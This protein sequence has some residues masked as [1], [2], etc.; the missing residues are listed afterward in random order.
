MY[1]SLML[2]IVEVV[3]G[4]RPQWE[5]FVEMWS[6]EEYAPL[7]SAM[8]DLASYLVDCYEQGKTA[9]FPALFSLVETQYGTDD[10]E[11]K[12]L[13]ALG[14]LETMQSVASHRPFGFQV[15]REWLGPRTL[16]SW[17]EV[18]EGMRRVAEWTREQNRPRW[19]QFWRRWTD[20]NPK[21]AL[22]EVESPELKRILE[23]EFR[24]LGDE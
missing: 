13:V 19:W 24:D 7:Y 18:D 4:F 20:F 14:L 5:A 2:E 22:A 9:E 16:V 1:T 3:P 23:G 6:D 17:D 10:N 12:T 11:L 21:K 15:F 8:G